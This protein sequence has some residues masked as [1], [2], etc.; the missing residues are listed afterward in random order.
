MDNKTIFIN[1]KFASEV[2]KFFLNKKYGIGR[3]CDDELERYYTKKENCDLGERILPVY[4][5]EPVIIPEPPVCDPPLCDEGAFGTAYFNLLSFSYPIITVDPP[6][7]TINFQ[8]PSLISLSYGVDRNVAISFNSYEDTLEFITVVND[9]FILNSIPLTLSFTETIPGAMGY[10]FV[11]T[12]NDKTDTY[13]NI[14]ASI[15]L[16]NLGT[17]GDYYDFNLES[18]INGGRIST[19]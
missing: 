11:L 16:T 13:N 1:T 9:L 10:G 14:V 18:T 7:T 4:C 19:C 17:P 8:I 2:Y 12:T 5:E 6:D 3:C 15:E